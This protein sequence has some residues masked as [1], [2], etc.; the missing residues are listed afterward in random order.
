MW[1]RSEIDIDEGIFALMGREVA[2]GNLPYTSLFDI[3]PVGLWVIFGLANALIGN[4]LI[5][6]RF[7]GTICVSI[8]AF[9]VYKIAQNASVSQRYAVVAPITYMAFT[10]QLTG[11]ATHTEIVLAPF[12]A[13]GVLILYRSMFV[14]SGRALVWQMVASGF[15]FGV[16][17]SVKTVV[18]IPSA[19][20]LIY[21]LYIKHSF[22]ELTKEKIITY[23]V[24]YV[25]SGSLLF[26][27]SA[28]L[29]ILAGHFEIFWYANFGFKLEYIASSESIGMLFRNIIRITTQIWPIF[30]IVFVFL[31]IC[32]TKFGYMKNRCKL[33]YI[34]MLIWIF[35]EGFAVAAPWQFFPHYFLLLI[36]P[37]AVALSLIT[38]HLTEEFIIDGKRRFV[39]LIVSLY[40]ALI[41]LVQHFYIPPWMNIIKPDVQRQMADIIKKYADVEGSVFLTTV[42]P[43]VYFLGDFKLATPYVFPSHLFGR[44]QSIVPVDTLAEIRRVMQGNAAVVVIERAGLA[45][46]DR[47]AVRAVEEGLGQYSMRGRYAL[48]GREFEVWVFDG[49]TAAAGGGR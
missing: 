48:L 9:I 37:S 17:F 35:A 27:L 28:L 21:V 5:S 38:R 10:T 22:N 19:A 30:T 41:P 36:P 6:I 43:M 42:E 39:P 11:L 34:F 49:P 8:T 33:T 15:S 40:I 2:R 20:L 23:F 1:W 25:A 32:I 16:A 18:A 29:Y 4:H 46:S 13:L 44:H 12:S 24:I 45:R 3:K 26:I 14:N 47:E 31:Y 7:L